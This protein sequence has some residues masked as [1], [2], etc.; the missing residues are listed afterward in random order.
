M[1]KEIAI[2]FEFKG[3]GHGNI[4][5]FPCESCEP[6]LQE[7]P[8]FKTFSISTGDY[9]LRIQGVVSMDGGTVKVLEGA[10]ELAALTL[11]TGYF[12]LPLNFTVS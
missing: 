7:E 2:S 9:L 6:Y 4:S 8:G 11:P 12:S 5:L 3:I 1:T 10:T